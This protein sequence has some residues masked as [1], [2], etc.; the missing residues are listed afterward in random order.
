MEV[1]SMDED[2]DRPLS[3]QECS[4]MTGLAVETLRYFRWRG[5]GGPRSYKVG[6]RVVYDRADVIEW[7]RLQKQATGVGGPPSPLGKLRAAPRH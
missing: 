1:N 2:Q 4:A 3:L 5:S 6:K 7:L